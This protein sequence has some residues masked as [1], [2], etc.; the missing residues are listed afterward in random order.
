MKMKYITLILLS[1]MFGYTTLAQDSLVDPKNEVDY[2]FGEGLNVSMSGGKHSFHLGG[3]I[4]PSFEHHFLDGKDLSIIQV[5]DARINFGAGLF[6]NR[7]LLYIDVDFTDPKALLDAYVGWNILNP[8]TP[9]KLLFSVGQKRSFV[10]SRENFMNEDDLMFFDRSPVSTDF[11]NTG[12]ELGFFLEGSFLAWGQLG[13]K[14]MLSVTSGDGRNSFGASSADPDKGGWKYGGRLDLLPLGE[15]ANNGDYTGRDLVH[16]ERPKLAFGAAWSYNMGASDPKGDGH[17][18]IMMYDSTQR[19]AYADYVKFYADVI[20]KWKGLTVLGEYVHSWANGREMLFLDDNLQ[21]PLTLAN[22]SEQYVLGD[23]YNVQVGYIFKKSKT[24]IDA[25]FSQT[26]PE[27]DLSTSILPLT[28]N[29][30]LGVTQYFTKSNAVR[31]QLIGNY[32]QTFGIGTETGTDSDLITAQLAI[33]V[34]F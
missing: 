8:M 10:N 30:S 24:S 15:F 4:T 32:I 12:R 1:A 18:T 33:Q 14:P 2:T 5:R 28:N 31:I 29:Y 19:E 21:T 16:E 34:K 3:F 11:A 23:A 13:I 9:Q 22:V 17:G 6:N 26:F 7:A 25:R 27:F 20:F